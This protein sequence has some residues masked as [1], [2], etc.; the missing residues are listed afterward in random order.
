MKL[1]SPFLVPFVS[2]MCVTFGI[3]SRPHFPAETPVIKGKVI[4]ASAVQ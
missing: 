2:S 4:R 1:V 3:Y